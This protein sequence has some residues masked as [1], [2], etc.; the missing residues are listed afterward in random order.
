MSFVFPFAG[1]ALR[2]GAPF[3]RYA[4]R[5]GPK[6]AKYAGYAGAVA[7]MRPSSKKVTVKATVKRN[8]KKVK[9]ARGFVENQEGGHS[10]TSSKFTKKIPRKSKL[11]REA[12]PEVW[13]NVQ[14]YTITTPEGRQQIQ[15]MNNVWTG[16]DCVAF[17]PNP[18]ALWNLA[19]FYVES[20]SMR[21]VYTNVTST[22]VKLTIYDLEPKTNGVQGEDGPT[23][24]VITGLK[25]K[26]DNDQF[27]YQVPYQS[28]KESKQFMS[29]WK[30]LNQKTVT[31][32]PGETHETYTHYDINKY[33]DNTMSKSSTPDG[34]T[35]T[36]YQWLKGFTKVQMVRLIGTPVTDGTK[37]STATSKVVCIS[38]RTL[39][40]RKPQGVSTIELVAHQ[41][42]KPDNNLTSQKTINE[43][44]MAVVTNVTV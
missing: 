25:I 18:S 41:A 11:L 8:T 7:A 24:S 10:I 15:D 2:Y 31:L 39:K 37:I 27:Q 35:S 30:I 1:Q 43:D 29:R 19:R 16:S 26:Y 38:Y 20:A 34:L 28:I 23:N 36:T 44:S 21:H 9:T 40:Y 4:S 42:N 12:L 14:T 6:A 3:F 22:P 13:K 5:Y 17:A 33:Y 32:S